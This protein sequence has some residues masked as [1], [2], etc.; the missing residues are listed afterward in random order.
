MLLSLFGT[1]SPLTYWTLHVLRIMAQTIDPDT[2]FIH[3]SRSSEWDCAWQS[4]EE[5]SR[6]NIVFFADCPDMAIAN[7]ILSQGLPA[8]VAA[9]DPGDLVAFIAAS[10]QWGIDQAS[11][12]ASQSLSALAAFSTG[13]SIWKVRN[14]AYGFIL[15]DYV[16]AIS[17]V[18]G[19]C[20]NGGQIKQVLHQLASAGMDAVTHQVGDE[21]L[22]CV[23]FARRPG[24]YDVAG[25]D[26]FDSDRLL[27]KQY[28]ALLLGQE[29]NHI[30]WPGSV[31]IDH[32]R[33]GHPLSGLQQ[34][35]GPARLLIYGPYL[36]L[37][38]GSWEAR[39][40]FDVYDNYSGNRIQA[41]VLSGAQDLLTAVTTLL[42]AQGAFA[43]VLR[44]DVTEPLLPL[45]IRVGILEGAIEGTL[46]L[47]QVH[48]A[49]SASGANTPAKLHPILR[50]MGAEAPAPAHRYA[51]EGAARALRDAAG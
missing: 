13:K 31:F 15:E 30:V 9:D 29:L 36:H 2:A 43:F 10:R 14:S 21:I 48:I 51:E 28:D 45:E 23:P 40:E 16:R 25:T 20:L 44:F 49:R 5:R 4:L 1:P 38:A 50:G 47:R 37:P 41:D 11:R 12:L 7:S 3:A 24:G 22:K 46:R 39:V 35:M 27:R 42:P 18:Y 8:I 17:N 19:L 6:R 34:L 32:D 26:V 33:P